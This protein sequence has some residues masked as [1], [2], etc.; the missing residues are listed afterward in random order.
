MKKHNQPPIIAQKIISLC[1]PNKVKDEILGDLQEEFNQ[2]SIKHG[3]TKAEYIYW[4]QVIISIF[5]FTI[6][7]TN[8]SILFSNSKQKCSLILGVAAFLISL[9]LISWLSHIEGF[10][11]FTNN[12]ETELAKGNLHQALTQAQFWQASIL[13]IKDTNNLEAYFQFDAFLWAITTA[14]LANIITKKKLISSTNMIIA[15]Y[16]ITFL[17]YLVGTIYLE[18]AYL[19]IQKAGPLLA[20]M[21]FS[22]FY[23]ILPTTYLTYKNLSERS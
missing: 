4:K 11:G 12:I 10:E 19:P 2:E 1:L 14:I 22:I 16:L 8:N 7:R 3:N 15:L 20:T 6:M 18:F 5:Q 23:L 21:I 17:P 9:L 13:N